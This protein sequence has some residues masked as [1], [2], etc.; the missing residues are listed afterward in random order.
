VF[1]ALQSAATD[2]TENEEPIGALVKFALDVVSSII[3]AVS[4]DYDSIQAS[5]AQSIWSETD[6]ARTDGQLSTTP[7]NSAS[8]QVGVKRKRD[9]K[10]DSAQKMKRK[11][12]LPL[13]SE[14]SLNE[15][16]DSNLS[17]SS[18]C[19]NFRK[20]K[21]QPVSSSSHLSQSYKDASAKDLIH[22]A[23]MMLP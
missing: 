8:V 2:M 1:I 13:A 19:Q 9:V 5:K 4:K 11:K 16:T 21:I 15:V 23:V 20:L 17:C 10:A 18:W 12:Q 14:A 7:I 22:Q 6:H 3:Q